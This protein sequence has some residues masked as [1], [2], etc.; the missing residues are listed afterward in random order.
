[1]RQSQNKAVVI[2]GSAGAFEVLLNLLSKLP[3]TYHLPIICV[4][5]MHP[6]DDGELAS[7][8]NEQ[9]SLMVKQAEEKEHI[10][11][12]FVYIA[13]ADYHL[14]VEHNKTFSL[15]IDEKVNYS[16]PSIDV[17]FESAA[18]AYMKNL[19]GIILS[20]SNH[21][22]ANGISKIKQY[23]GC[24]IAQSPLSAKYKIM[25]QAAID[26]GDIDFIF[27]I[28]EIMDMLLKGINHGL[29]TENFNC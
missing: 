10:C 11:P 20:G 4:M 25:P 2:G 7:F 24:T 13:P 8:L 28:P 18:F 17:L 12:G 29:Q 16:R 3:K 6:S 21:D 5:H 23:D 1:M 26:T 14:L 9:S 27:S 15:S 22:G 19:T